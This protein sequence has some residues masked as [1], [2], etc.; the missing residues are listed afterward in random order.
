MNYLTQTLDKARQCYERTL[1]Y[2][3]EPT[4]IH[5]VLLRLATIYLKEGQVLR[6]LYGRILDLCANIVD[7]M[8]LSFQF[9]KAKRQFLLACKRT[10]S[11]VSWLGVGI[12]CYE[13]QICC[14]IYICYK[15]GRS[16]DFLVH[17]WDP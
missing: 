6:Q 4:D 16:F 5:S 15:V 12:S 9:D 7:K 11:P 1:A 2:V 8:H 17:S 10:P 3:D 14:Y 13:V